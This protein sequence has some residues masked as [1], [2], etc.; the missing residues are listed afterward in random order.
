MSDNDATKALVRTGAEMTRREFGGTDVAPV[1]ET[2]A[3]ALSEQQRAEVESRFVMARRFPR[4][5]DNVRVRMKA[6]CQR[7]GFAAI[8]RYKIPNRGEGWTIRFAEA[9]ARHFGNLFIAAR[10]IYDDREKRILS[11]TG[12][13]LETNNTESV[14][15]VVEKTVE[16]GPGA[17]GGREPIPGLTRKNKDGGVVHTV[18][19]TDDELPAKQNSLV[20]KA[21]RN[22]IMML[23]PG[24]IADE[25]KPLVLKTQQDRDAKDPGAARKEICDAFAGLNVMPDQ[26]KAYLGHDI[27]TCS[28]AELGDLRQLYAAIRDNH[29]NWTEIMKDRTAERA[30]TETTPANAPPRT[31]TD[32]KVRAAAAKAGATTTTSAPAADG[33]KCLG[34]VLPHGVVAGCPVHDRQTPPEP[35]TEG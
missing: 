27:A 8:A 21:R 1:T 11:V 5:V 13:D 28:P 3:Q 12:V 10:V 7:P 26:L 16:R 18:W 14:D 23:F 31:T 6:E 35:G 22:V 32:I 34:C 15:V 4:D 33:A 25:C 20:S 29:T 17:L 19:A 30:A 2:A 24:E 9:A